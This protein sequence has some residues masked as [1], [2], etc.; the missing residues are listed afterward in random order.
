MALGLTQPLT[1]ISTRNL[2]KGKGLRRVMLTNSPPSVSRLPRWCWSLDVSNNPMALHCLV[3]GQLFLYALLAYLYNL[4]ETCCSSDE[5]CLRLCVTCLLQLES[6][7]Y[8]TK[9]CTLWILDY[10][11]RPTLALADSSNSSYKQSSSRNIW[12]NFVSIFNPQWLLNHIQFLYLEL[13]SD[14]KMPM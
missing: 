8:K 4:Y 10:V 7:L 12:H 1:E 2:S 6:V 9:V 5:D 14:P 3:Q 11:I 13:S